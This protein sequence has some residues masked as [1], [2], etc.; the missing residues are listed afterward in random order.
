VFERPP[1][2]LH[3]SLRFWGINDLD[4]RYGEWN[5]PRWRPA[6]AARICLGFIA[7]EYY[8]LIAN[9]VLAVLLTTRDVLVIKAGGFVMAPAYVSEEWHWPLY[10]TSES[11]LTKYAGIPADSSEILNISRANRRLPLNSIGSVDFVVRRK[12]GMGS[13]PYSGRILLSTLSRRHEFILLGNQSG[14]EITT[15]LRSAVFAAK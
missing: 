9:R 12:W 13:V 11:L 15:Q 2:Q 1:V 5:H 7:L 14:D 3:S 8:A 6:R 10:Y 4:C